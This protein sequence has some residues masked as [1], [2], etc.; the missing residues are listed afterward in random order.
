MHRTPSFRWAPSRTLGLCAVL[1]LF[2]SASLLAVP[3]RAQDA[4]PDSQSV[5]EAARQEKARKAAQQKKDSHV[6]TNEDLKQSQIL[7]QHDRAQ[8]EARTN[9]SPAAP[10]A[11]ADPSVS[12]EKNSAPESLGEVARRYRRQKLE[13]AQAAEAAK[14]QP[15]SRFP[16]N[17]SQPSFA[18]PVQAAAPP[19]LSLVAPN[20]HPRPQATPLQNIAPARPDPFSRQRFSPALPNERAPFTPNFSA[21]PKPA[22]SLTA[23]APHAP[24]VHAVPPAAAAQKLLLPAKPVPARPSLAPPN[25]PATPSINHL[26]GNQIRIQPGDSLWKLA[27]RHLGCGS[28]WSDLLAANPT[29]S[30]PLH[31]QPGAVLVV[32]ATEL[33]SRVQPPSTTIHSGDSLWKIAA[34]HLGSATAWPCIAQA[35]P[36][37]RDANLLRPGQLLILP[38]SCPNKRRL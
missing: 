33:R 12:A 27:R 17:L 36:Q 31:L 16:M 37:L 23:P 9:N 20:S 8:V 38:A 22:I 29:I 3:S 13:N 7:T 34:S 21:P 28:R 14:Q 18:A 15:P 5:A 10:V 6:Y 11:P 25:A 2:A 30:D 24:A 32:P 26:S 4:Q 1:C 35:N 19:V